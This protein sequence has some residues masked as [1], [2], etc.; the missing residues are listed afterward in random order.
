MFPVR[1]SEAFPE[2]GISMPDIRKWESKKLGVAIEIDYEKC[3]G[4]GRCVEVCPSSVYEIVNGKTT[5]PNL[6]HV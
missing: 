3:S 2:G 1:F 5:C 4:I 6:L